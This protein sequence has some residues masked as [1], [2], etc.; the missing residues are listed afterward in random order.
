MKLTLILT[1]LLIFLVGCSTVPKSEPAINTTQNTTHIIPKILDL[2]LNEQDNTQLQLSNNLNEQEL[3]QLGFTNNK[4][5]CQSD[6][7]YTNIDSSQNQ[8]NICI[9]NINNLNTSVI[10]ELTKYANSTELNYAYQYSSGHLYSVQGIISENDYGD[11]S[12][13]RVNDI[14]D[15]GGEFNDPNMFYYHLWICKD[16][17]LIHITSAGTNKEAKEYVAKIGRQILSKFE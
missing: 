8:H 10:I 5:N 11:Q 13:F 4:T 9:Y 3:A 1:I 15:Y 12:K 16:T 7:D 2:T 14:H 6:A 17:Y